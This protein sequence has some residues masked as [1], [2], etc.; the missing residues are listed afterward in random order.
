MNAINLVKPEAQI[1]NKFTPLTLAEVLALYTV[2]H[3]AQQ[4]KQYASCAY[5]AEIY[6]EGRAIIS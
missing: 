4:R 2:N 1:K 3:P 5:F 6:T